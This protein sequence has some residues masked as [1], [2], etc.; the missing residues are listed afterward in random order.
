M[1]ERKDLATTD[2]SAVQYEEVKFNLYREA[3]EIRN[4]NYK[5]VLK[6][7]KEAGDIK[8]R[9]KDICNP[10]FNW[11]Q[12]GFSDKILTVTEKRGYSKPFPIQAQTMPLIM[13]GRDVIGIAETGS[14]KTMSYLLP[15]LKHI[16]AQRPVE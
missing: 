9:G 12:C 14:G 15:T 4:M 3:E 1:A 8:V 7:R 10:I 2:H 16:M 6:Y 5:D 13:S 11:Y